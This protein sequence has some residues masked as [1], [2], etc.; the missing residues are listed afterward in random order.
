[1]VPLDFMRHPEPRGRITHGFCRM[2]CNIY[3]G[4][5]QAN[6]TAAEATYYKL[7]WRV[8]LVVRSS[9][10]SPA[11]WLPPE[12]CAGSILLACCRFSGLVLALARHLY[13]WLHCVLTG[14]C[15]ISRDPR[16]V[17]LTAAEA[18]YYKLPWRVRLVVRSSGVYPAFWLPPE[19]CAGFTVM[20]CFELAGV[21]LAR[22]GRARCS[23]IGS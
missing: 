23:C 15:D 16:C 2:T 20:A 5:C 6:G 19:G 12:G 17:R 10:V 18:A 9:G 14:T 7:P 4:L 11:F 8:R 3:R 13:S 21:V 22:P 1:M